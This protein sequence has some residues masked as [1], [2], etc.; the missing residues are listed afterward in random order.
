M[1]P[2]VVKLGS[3]ISEIDD[4][5][6]EVSCCDTTRFGSASSRDI[7]EAADLLTAARRRVVDGMMT[8]GRFQNLEKTLGLNHAPHGIFCDVLLRS[9][10]DF[11]SV[12]TVDWVHCML[13]DGVMTLESYLLVCAAD[14]AVSMQDLETY[15][16]SNGWCFPAASHAKSRVLWQVFDTHRNP[17]QEKLKASASEMLGSW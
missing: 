14:P 9:E 2:K 12:Y 13:Q 4:S 7:Y 8:K 15:M 11:A 16:K 10:I 3:G 5:F 6:V 1:H 17:T